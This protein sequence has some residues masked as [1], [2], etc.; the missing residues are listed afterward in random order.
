MAHPDLENLLNALLPFAQEMLGKYGE[1]Y[2]FGA[3]VQSDGSVALIG[4]ADGTEHP[5]STDLI[6]LLEAGLRKDAAEKKIRASGICFDVRVRVPDQEHKTDAI[7][8]SLEHLEGKV[9]NVFLPYEKKFWK[10]IHY[11][12]MFASKG[13][14]KIFCDL[15]RF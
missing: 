12:K 1:F 6:G 7:Q 5:K 15:Q 3:S 8:V 9:V 11:G 2:P 10:R 13:D 14:M 4:A